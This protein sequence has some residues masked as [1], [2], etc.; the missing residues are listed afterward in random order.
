[1]VGDPED[2]VLGMGLLGIEVGSFG[3][4]RSDT[5]LATRRLPQSLQRAQEKLVTD[6]TGRNPSLVT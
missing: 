5:G 2:T 3:N 6:L 1:M 4:G